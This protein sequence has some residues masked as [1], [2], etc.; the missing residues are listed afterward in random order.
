MDTNGLKRFAAEARTILI[1]GVRNRVEGL[2]F[3]LK[4]GQPAAL[5]Q[6]KGGGAVFRDESPV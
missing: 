4:S 5:P 3:D 1:Q 6:L 2:G